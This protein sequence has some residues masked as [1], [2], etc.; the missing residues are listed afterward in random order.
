MAVKVPA[1]VS[2]LNKNGLEALKRL[3]NKKPEDQTQPNNQPTRRTLSKIAELKKEKESAIKTAEELQAELEA[4]RAKTA[5]IEA[6][7]DEYKNK[8]T[9]YEP[10]AQAFSKMKRKTIAEIIGKL[11]QEKQAKAKSMSEKLGLD[12]F[13]EWVVGYSAPVQQQDEGKGKGI[14]FAAIMAKNDQKALDEAAVQDP[15]GYQKFITS[16]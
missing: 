5:Q 11:P 13:K 10:D 2:E 15:E 14:D 16:I 9:E 12:D 1:D 3:Q 7:R 6:E 8:A 4:E